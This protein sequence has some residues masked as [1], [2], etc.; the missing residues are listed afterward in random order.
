MSPQIDRPAPPYQQ[1]VRHIR[2]QIESG[3]LASGDRIPS[4]RQLA[5]NWGISLATAAK[6]LTALRSEGLVRGVSGVGTIVTPR[7]MALGGQDRMLASAAGQI[8]PQVEHARIQAA[9]LVSAPDQVA[10]ALGVNHGS[11]VLRRQRI[12]YREEDPAPVPVSASTSWF[13]GAVVTAAPR[14]L[15]IT[16]I[17]EGTPRYI[18][19]MTGR[20]MTTGKDQVTADTATDQEAAHLSIPVGAAILRSRN[21]VYDATGDVIEYG[22]S[23]Y[24]AHRWRSYEYEITR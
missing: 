13:D 11:P 6:A 4:A 24:A 5:K 3:E 20:A 16:R 7:A 18:E 2:S 21:W 8:Y 9:E 10:D 22:E 19:K 12:T 1:V 14:L 17:K 23:V 15:E